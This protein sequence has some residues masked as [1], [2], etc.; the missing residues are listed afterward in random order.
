MKT[1][2][3]KSSF[4]IL[5][6]TFIFTIL[7]FTKSLHFEVWDQV[8][9]MNQVELDTTSIDML[10]HLPRYI[11]VYPAYFVSEFF[12]IDLSFVYGY[13]LLISTALISILWEKSR[14]MFFFEKTKFSLV[15]LIPYIFL[16]FV[17][18][19]FI[20]GLLGLSTLLW[21]SISY[22]RSDLSLPKVIGMFVGLL[23]CSISS[24]VFVVG[25]LFLLL[26]FIDVNKHKT[27]GKRVFGWFALFLILTPSIVL[28]NIFIV[29][30]FTY[31][32]DEGYGVFGILSHGL[33]VF[34]NPDPLVEN[35]SGESMG[36]VLC[37]VAST[38]SEIGLVFSGTLALLLVLIIVF[39]IKKLKLPKLAK[40]GLVISAFGGI[41]GFTTLMSFIFVLPICINRNYLSLVPN[42]EDPIRNFE[43]ENKVGLNLATEVTSDPLVG[44][45]K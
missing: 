35:C 36:S 8:E 25:L 23:F 6:S 27:R 26:S 15:L 44:N 9:F 28:A 5:I 32:E 31:F 12:D 42:A 11:V 13:Y 38:L 33:G 18:G 4:L 14:E 17:N 16:F 41:F 3:V 19:R 37:T 21:L 34:L 45:I 22:A 43:D 29:K 30:N 39:F 7:L 10:A 2:R 40:R 20:F 24:G 1:R